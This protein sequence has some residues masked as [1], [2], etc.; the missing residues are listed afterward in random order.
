MKG[1]FCL[2]NLTSF[3]DKVICLMD[4]EKVVDV[5]TWILTK[6]M[7]WVPTV[8]SWRLWLPMVFTEKKTGWMAEF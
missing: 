5:F 2:T 7:I 4:E 1:R 8:F 6:P 3:Y